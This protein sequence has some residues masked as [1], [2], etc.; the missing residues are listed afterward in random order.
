MHFPIQMWRTEGCL[1]T[2]TA[3]G[4]ETLYSALPP[5]VVLP[6]TLDS[7]HATRRSRTRALW[8]TVYNQCKRTKSRSKQ[9]S[10]IM[11]VPITFVHHNGRFPVFVASRRVEALQHSLSDVS[12]HCP[13]KPIA[14]GINQT[15]CKYKRWSVTSE[16]ACQDLISVLRTLRPL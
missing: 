6:K 3:K 7:S 11:G 16:R 10:S 14:F 2:W 15:R 9:I 1:Y 8:R 13:Q 5:P 4:L 12:E